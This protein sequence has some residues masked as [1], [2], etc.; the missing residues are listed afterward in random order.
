MPGPLAADTDPAPATKPGT[1]PR[2]CPLR[3]G[4]GHAANRKG[5]PRSPTAARVTRRAANGRAPA[6]TGP[7]QKKTAPGNP[8]KASG[9]ASRGGW[10]PG[11]VASQ[12]AFPGR[13]NVF[14]FPLLSVGLIVGTVRARPGLYAGV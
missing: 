12:P 3:G 9:R 2:H 14:S 7:T 10:L 8:D 11:A 1:F 4:A 6:P 13:S 5:S